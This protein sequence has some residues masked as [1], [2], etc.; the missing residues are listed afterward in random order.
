MFIDS[1]CRKSVVTSEIISERC[2]SWRGS[3]DVDL[4]VEP[5]ARLVVSLLVKRVMGGVLR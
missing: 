2:E 4:C 1:V 5:S 3:N